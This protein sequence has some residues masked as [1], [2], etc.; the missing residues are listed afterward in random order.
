MSA[1]LRIAIFENGRLVHEGDYAEPVELG[2]QDPDDGEVYQ[3]AQK[4]KRWRIVV[5]RKDEARVSKKQLLVEALPGNRVRLRNISKG[6]SIDLKEEGKLKPGGTLERTLPVKLDIGGREVAIEGLNLQSLASAPPPPGARRFDRSIFQTIAD[7]PTLQAESVIPI[8]ETTMEVIQGAAESDCF[9]RAARALVEVEMIGMD[10]GRVLLLERN[11]W[12][13]KAE[14]R[15]ARLRAASE[16]SWKP[17]SRILQRVREEKKTFWQIPPSRQGSMAGVEALIVA[18]ILDRDGQ[19]IGVLYGDRGADGPA[20]RAGAGPVRPFEAM[21]V[22][23]LASGVAAAL[24]KKKLVLMEH[25]LEFGR[26]LQ[27]GFL[28]RDLPQPAS[29]ELA[30]H[31]R[32]AHEISGDFYDAFA[33]PG[34]L[35]GLV[36]ADVCGKGVGPGLY[37]ALARS[38]LRAFAVQAA[39]SGEDTGPRLADRIAV[40]ALKLTNNYIAENHRDCM[41]AT[42]FFGVLDTASGALT[43]INAGHDPLPVL[44]GSNRV[45]ARL[46]PTAKMVGPEPQCDY[47]TKTVV[48]EPGDTLFAYTDGVT[49]ARSPGGR[50]EDRFDEK[51]LL[52]VLEKPAATAAALVEAVKAALDQHSAG[53]EP[54]DDVTMLAVRRVP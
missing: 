1:A 7:E 25:D 36:I 24:A 12:V 21:L 17:S 30:V 52:A 22:Q 41:F 40:S 33:L 29:W 28:P 11:D 50:V 20:A 3:A 38:M 18:P 48:L 39:G 6:A 51:R 8:L 54:F 37:M 34:G 46:A 14:K 43:H 47:E 16:R 2:R 23:L 26:E 45:K 9:E 4:D 19:V 32:P 10:A 42:V 13:V 53:A 5:A 27:A 31:F 49:D 15:R 35:V 44:L